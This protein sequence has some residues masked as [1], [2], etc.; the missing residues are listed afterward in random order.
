MRARARRTHDRPVR[1]PNPALLAVLA[2]AGVIAGAGPAAADGSLAPGQTQTVVVPVPDRWAA[3]ADAVAVVVDDLV[4]L[5]N[6]CI[7]PERK[8]GDD[9]RDTSGELGDKLVAT[10]AWGT[11]DG[12]GCRP[13]VV[14]APLALAGLGGTR[15]ESTRFQHVVGVECL[16]L[17][18]TFPDGDS[19][20]VAQSDSLTF[21]LDAV[22]EEVPGEVVSTVEPE[23]V[24][25]TPSADGSSGTEPQNSANPSSA[26][27][28]TARGPVA[29]SAAAGHGARGGTAAPA[30]ERAAAVQ[31][32][33]PAGPM[34]GRVDAQVSVGADGISVETRAAGTS[35]PGS[36][37]A[38][39]SM[40]LGAVALGWV[41]FVLVRRRRT[42]VVA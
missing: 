4:Q 34:V 1:R 35:L 37:L 26:G 27:A 41:A 39:S 40:L 38:W 9:C 11:V 36:A 2:A 33:G 13:A 12:D 31:R 15:A 25:P 20:N 22:G 10:V 6:D 21:R 3:D 24:D 29:R 32:R 17:N 30:A 7:E 16:V 18:L 14:M 19:D 5:E 28:A 8:A 42:D 23:G